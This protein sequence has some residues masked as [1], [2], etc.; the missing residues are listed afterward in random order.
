MNPPAITPL[1]ISDTSSLQLLEA[2]ERNVKE[3]GGDRRRNSL[4]AIMAVP[5]HSTLIVYRYVNSF[6][7]WILIDCGSA[8]NS[9]NDSLIPKVSLVTHEIV[10]FGVRIGNGDII[11]CN[12]VCKNVPLHLNDLQITQDFYPLSMGS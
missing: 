3:F 8:H 10:P 11:R 9:I 12:Q 1:R 2:G 6:K 5:H 4:H 7:V